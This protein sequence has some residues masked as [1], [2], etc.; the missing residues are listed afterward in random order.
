M[1]Q[2]LQRRIVE[3]LAFPAGMGFTIGVYALIQW[4]KDRRESKR[5]EAAWAEYWANN[6]LVTPDEVKAM[7]HPYS[8]GNGES[9][10]K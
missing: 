2:E 9:Q 3:E 8:Q 5:L 1:N 6:R 7:R 10:E 4:F